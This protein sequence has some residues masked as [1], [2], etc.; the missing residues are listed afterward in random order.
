MFRLR[1]ACALLLIVALPAISDTWTLAQDNPQQART[2]VHLHWGA[3]PGITRYR[4]QLAADRDF[5]DIVF[6]SIITGT[7]KDVNDLAP[8]KYFWRIAPLTR[9][10]GEFSSAAAI[11][12]SPADKAV[13]DLPPAQPTVAVPKLPAKPITT[14]GGW[15]AAVGDVARPVIAHLRSRDSFD[16]VAMN[17]N[18]VTFALDS[19]TG[20]GFWS[21][22]RT[23]SAS[24][25]VLQVIPPLI[26]QSPS[27]LDDVLVFDGLVAI[28]LEGKSGRELWRTPLSTPPAS[29]VV[30]RDGANSIL[31]VVDT[32]LRYLLVLNATS[33]QVISRSSLPARV[34]GPVA[35]SLDQN[36]QFFIAYETGD[37]ELRDK[38]GAVLRSGSAASPAT[39]GPLVVKARRDNVVKRQD[40]LL[41]DTREGLTGITAGDLK[42][43]G[44]V[45]SKEEMSRGNLVAADLDGDGE[46]EVLIATRDGY[47]LAIHSENGK[48][49]WDA[50]VK[51]TPLGMAFVDLDGDNI[52]DVIMT[53]A[54]SFATALS[55]RDGSPIWQDGEPAGPVANSAGGRGIV[56]APLNSGVL[57]IATDVSHTGL[58]AVQ[59]SQAAVLR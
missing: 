45:T 29:T 28:R 32:S 38:A 53:T 56:V 49:L 44:R 12:T 9:T 48:I 43:L 34:S 58:R 26:I 11:D 37:L 1:I 5:R 52:L 23:R 22:R 18:G 7:E 33:G 15:R 57:V 42:P 4:L 31:A 55:G 17:S 13:D 16:V 10:L 3:R 6:D 24:V 20:V 50:T 39:T 35:G 8:G 30:V 47:L 51:E 40:M 25:P 21:T 41:V 46:A 19:A 2:K 54:T 14:T 27:G 59:F 36:G